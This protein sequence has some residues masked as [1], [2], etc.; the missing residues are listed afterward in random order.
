MRVFLVIV[1]VAYWGCSSLAQSML[2]SSGTCDPSVIHRPDLE[3]V[4]AADLNP[5]RD[6]V[7]QV[8]PIIDVPLNGRH[9]QSDVFLWFS[10]DI[11]T[12]EVDLFTYAA[13][14]GC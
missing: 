12:G 3:D 8:N 6:T 14:S 1:A 7:D 13:Q 9:A 11:E 5:F 2:A 10:P 4:S